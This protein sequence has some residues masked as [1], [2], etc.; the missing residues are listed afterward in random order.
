MQNAAL[1]RDMSVEDAIEL[2]RRSIYH[3]TF[4][5]AVSGGTVSG[6]SIS[7]LLAQCCTSS[8]AGAC[9]VHKADGRLAKSEPWASGVQC[10]MSQLTGGR[11]SEEM[12]WAS[13]T[14]STILL[15][16]DIP[17]MALI[18]S[19][20]TLFLAKGS[21]GCYK[22]PVQMLSGAIFAGIGWILCI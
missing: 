16:R 5:D 12:M 11:R 7:L 8:L 20:S 6:K 14:T 15:V 17:A 10:T 21:A 18:P 4:R 9:Q 1:C 2:G 13:Y 3:A 19:D 22:G